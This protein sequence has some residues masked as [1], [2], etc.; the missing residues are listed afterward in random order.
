MYEL[1][2]REINLCNIKCLIETAT[3]FGRF[4]ILVEKISLRSLN[5]NGTQ[6][7]G[8]GH[9]PESSK[10]EGTAKDYTPLS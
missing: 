8:L 6:N 3:I 7:G 4:K 9:V 5:A 10:C 1:I 2:L